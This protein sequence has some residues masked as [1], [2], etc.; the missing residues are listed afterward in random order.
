MLS[1]LGTPGPLWTWFNSYLSNR[2]HKVCIKGWESSCLPVRSGAPQGSIL[3][4]LPFLVYV[5]DIM[6]AVTSSGIQLYAD[7]AQCV[8]DINN[9]SDCELLQQYLDGLSVWGLTTNSKNSRILY[10]ILM[11]NST[12]D[13]NSVGVSHIYDVL[14]QASETY[15]GIGLSILGFIE[16]NASS[17]EQYGT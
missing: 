10:I 9:S 11:I 14:L 7:D 17:K 16:K 8:N 13:P 15:T 2:Y 5:N 4:L 3:C 6:P 1:F 12:T